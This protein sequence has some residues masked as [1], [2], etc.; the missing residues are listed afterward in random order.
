MQPTADVIARGPSSPDDLVVAATTAQVP[1]PAFAAWL[2]PVNV[3]IGK[4]RRTLLGS[5]VL[6]EPPCQLLGHAGALV[7]D[8]YSHFGLVAAQPHLHRRSVRGMA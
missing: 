5:P 1:S 3:A 4:P 7:F 8:Q 2:L 6:G